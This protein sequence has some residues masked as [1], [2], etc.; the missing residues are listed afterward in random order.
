MSYEIK[1][2]NLTYLVLGERADNFLSWVLINLYV[3]EFLTGLL[4]FVETIAFLIM[5]IIAFFNLLVGV[6][7]TMAALLVTSLFVLSQVILLATLHSVSVSNK[8]TTVS[9]P[10]LYLVNSYSSF[11]PNNN[12]WLKV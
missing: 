2:I 11:L 1:F 5:S 6:S 4:Y 3:N 10:N 9:I 8:N 12:L 7:E